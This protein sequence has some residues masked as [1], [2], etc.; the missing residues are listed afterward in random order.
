MSTELEE[1]LLALVS[2]GSFTVGVWGLYDMFA[3]WKMIF[4]NPS[5]VELSGNLAG[6]NIYTK[7]AAEKKAEG[8]VKVA[9]IQLKI[10]N[11]QR[12]RAGLP[13]I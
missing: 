4:G 12:Q 9:E 8:D 6:D 10:E 3:F 1:A 2:I 13:P 11:S 7:Q 5:K